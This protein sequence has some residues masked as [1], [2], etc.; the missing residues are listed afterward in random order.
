MNKVLNRNKLIKIIS[1]IIVVF[2]LIISAIFLFN[3]KD[4]EYKELPKVKLKEQSNSKQFALM[5]E[6]DNGEY[7]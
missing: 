5:L 3:N 1:F 4:N 2:A 7:K 6:Q